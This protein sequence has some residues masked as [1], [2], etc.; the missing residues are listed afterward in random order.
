MTGAIPTLLH[1][2]SWSAQGQIYVSLTVRILTFRSQYQCPWFKPHTI[3][4]NEHTIV[5]GPIIKQTEV[6]TP[7]PDSHV[8]I[9]RRGQC[10]IEAN[11][12]TVVF[13]CCYRGPDKKH[14]NIL[15]NLH[16]ALVMSWSFWIRF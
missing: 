10:L 8:T 2:S 1:V 3:S 9:F 5:T 12:L 11:S 4:N 15:Q 14:P 6:T 7:F 13:P 16:H